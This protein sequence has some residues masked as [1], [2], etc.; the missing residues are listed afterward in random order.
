MSNGYIGNQPKFGVFL[1]VSIPSGTKTVTLAYAPGSAAAVQV[2]VNKQI[3]QPDVDYTVDDKVLTFTAVT[4]ASGWLR[5]LGIEIGNADNSSLQGFKDLL[6]SYLGAENVGYKVSYNFGLNRTI[7]DRLNDRVDAM[8]VQ[9]ITADG[10]ANDY[11]GFQALQAEI[12]GRV[13]DLNGRTC[14]VSTLPTGNVYINGSFITPSLVDGTNTT[15]KL[16]TLASIISSATDTGGY[17]VRYQNPLTGDYQLSGR[18]TQDLYVLIASQNSRSAGPARAVNIGSIYSYATGNVSGNYSARQ[19]R[20]T[21]PQSFNIGSEDCRA[22]GGFRGSNIGSITSHVTG[23]S[24]TNIISRRGWATGFHAGNFAS[25]DATA[26][27][28]KGAILKPIVNSSGVLTGV[29]VVAG[30]AGYSDAATVQFYDRNSAPTTVAVATY[31]LVAGTGAIASVTVTTQGVGYSTDTSTEYEVVQ[32]TIMDSGNYSANIATANNCVTYGE[33]SFNLGSNNS[34]T[35]AARSGNLASNGSSTSNLYALNLGTTTSIASN[36]YSFNLG[37]ASSTASGTNS[38][39]IGSSTSTASGTRS[40]NIAQDGSSTSGVGSVNIGGAGANQITADNAM[41]INGNQCVNDQ[42]G[43]TVFGRR[44]RPRALRSLV[45]GDS[46]SGSAATANIKFEVT[47]AGAVNSAGAM[48]QNVTF[49]DLAKMFENEVEGT[50][51]PVGALVTIVGRKVRLAVAGDLGSEISA[52]SRTYAVLFGDSQF[53]WADRYVRDKF[54]I[55][56]THEVP[57][58]DWKEFI[59]DPNWPEK[60][61]NPEHPKYDLVPIL[62]GEGSETGQYFNMLV[63]SEYIINDEPPALVPNPEPQPMVTVQMENPDFN[64]DEPQKPRSE[65][66]DEWTPV[67]LIGEVHVRVDGTLKIDDYVTASDVPGIGTKSEIKTKLRVMEITHE[68]DDDGYAVALC[69]RD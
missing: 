41:I 51:I 49:T 69:L 22:D 53:T 25:V 52:H 50:E 31:T 43:A 36:V 18:S 17:E 5:F 6:A 47:S 14:Y 9:G 1:P 20:A 3:L 63:S 10:V 42:L 45:F 29:T 7:S 12:T 27:G 21:V 2:V 57:D 32:A 34:V 15:L 46:S 4:S 8:D 13:I 65:R 37:S 56:K 64:I 24:G 28:G 68:L 61:L 54:G 38:G 67:A 66:Y 33:I 40:L 62:D 16:P 44:A 26:G 60:V 39:N 59:P 30:G 55:I 48:T 19:C 35:K 23:E 58:E 11:P